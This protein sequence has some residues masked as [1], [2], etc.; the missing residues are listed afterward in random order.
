VE[1]TKKIKNNRDRSAPK[2]T[3]RKQHELVEV[4]PE[5]EPVIEIKKKISF[6][7]SIEEVNEDD[8]PL[9]DMGNGDEEAPPVPS[10]NR[11]GR[12]SFFNYSDYGALQ[13]KLSFSEEESDFTDS[14]SND[15]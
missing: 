14:Q 13:E 12:K 4:E 5:E 15:H 3:R 9:D 6:G 10:R 2:N 11:K 8:I 1:K 7:E